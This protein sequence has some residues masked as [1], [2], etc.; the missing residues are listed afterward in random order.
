M[1]IHIHTQQGSR[2]IG[3]HMPLHIALAVLP[4]LPRPLLVRLVANA[5]DLLD[6][7]MATPTLSPR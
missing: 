1:A 4:Q 6:L 5:I 3:A 7:R 2:A